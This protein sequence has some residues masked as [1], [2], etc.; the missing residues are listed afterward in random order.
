MELKRD[1]SGNPIIDQLSEEGF[2]DC[3]FLIKNLSSKDGNYEFDV[4]ASYN[5][6]EV[7]FRVKIYKDMKGGLTRRMK[8]KN[9]YYEGITFI[10]SGPES[11]RFI[12]A[13]AELY[14]LEKKDLQMVNSVSFTSIILHQNPIDFSSEEI[15]IKIFGKDGEDDAE[16]DYNESYFKLDLANG[17]AYFNEKDLCYRDPLIRHLTRK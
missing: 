14:G 11:D 3:V 1:A 6:N 15:R 16:E 4:V 8:L 7:G 10:R 12:I 2:I 9:V 17:L 5:G 13:L